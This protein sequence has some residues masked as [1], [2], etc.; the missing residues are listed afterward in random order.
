MSLSLGERVNVI[1]PERPPFGELNH[2]TSDLLAM[3]LV[4]EPDVFLA[5]RDHETIGTI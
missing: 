1:G 2:S 3:K 5:L 4:T